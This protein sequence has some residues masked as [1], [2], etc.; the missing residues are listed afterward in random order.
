MTSGSGGDRVV[1]VGTPRSSQQQ[2]AKCDPEGRTTR[3]RDELLRGVR[4]FHL[5]H[6]SVNS[7][8]HKVRKPVHVLYYR[9]ASLGLVEIV[10]VLHE[11]MKP[12][13][14]IREP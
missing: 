9:A 3:G 8:K 6:A 1:G 2:C 13:R 7:P 11:Y 5:K 12:S 10:R 14:Y 4:S